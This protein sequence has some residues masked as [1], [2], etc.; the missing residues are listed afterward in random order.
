MSIDTRGTRL[1]DLQAHWA[2][3]DIA[4][5]PIWGTGAVVQY[6]VLLVIAI[7]NIQ[8]EVGPLFAKYAFQGLAKLDLAI[9]KCWMYV[10]TFQARGSLHQRGGLDS[11]FP[12]I[13]YG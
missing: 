5:P 7:K 2:L 8:K 10:Q 11:T 4:Q 9:P 13:R 3:L 12:I 6:C 1:L